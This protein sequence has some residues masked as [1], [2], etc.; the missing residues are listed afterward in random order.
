MRCAAA[1][2]AWAH[3][4]EALV[5]P[6][7]AAHEAIAAHEGAAPGS[8][9]GALDEV[10]LLRRADNVDP[11]VWADLA[12]DLR[13]SVSASDLAP[14]AV[15]EVSPTDLARSLRHFEVHE[16]ALLRYVTL[17]R[18]APGSPESA[19]GS[20]IRWMHEDFLWDSTAICYALAVVG[21]DT[22][23]VSQPKRAQSN[24]RQRARAGVSNQAWDLTLLSHWQKQVER[25]N[26]TNRI[27]IL[28]SLDAGLHRIA[29]RVAIGTATTDYEAL[30]TERWGQSARD[31]ARQMKDL[32]ASHDDAR[33]QR[34][35]KLDR[36][37]IDAL[38]SNLENA[39]A[40]TFPRQ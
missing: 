27:P 1:I 26:D 21:T 24:D 40:A 2:L 16:L 13:T 28:A 7:I 37:T 5:D 15:L 10:Q 14:E 39:F 6:S 22:G 29:R 32:Q 33:E 38:R 19:A 12:L 31:L 23:Q 17:L 25:M 9:A 8:A 11:Q 34:L 18:E 4:I 20:L 35:A 36:A 3:C 30:W